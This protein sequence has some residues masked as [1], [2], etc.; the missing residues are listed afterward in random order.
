MHVEETVNPFRDAEGRPRGFLAIQRDVTE[1]RR[2]EQERDDLREQ[3]LA[4]QKLD[5]VGRLAGGIAHDFNNLLAVIL[6]LADMVHASIEDDATRADVQHIRDAGER[7]AELTRQLLTFSRRQVV[8]LTLVDV[9]VLVS[10][11]VTMLR[12]TLG[13]DIEIRTDLAPDAGQVRADKGQLEQVLMNLAVNARDATPHGGTYVCNVAA[14]G[15]DRLGTDHRVRHRLRHGCRYPP[16]CVRAVLHY[17]GSGARHRAG[18][19]HRVRDRAPVGRHHRTA[20]RAGSWNPVHHRVRSS[21]SRP[22]PAPVLRAFA[23]ARNRSCS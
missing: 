6:N 23:E 5:A 18:P 3:Y 19:R 22:R 21:I 1:R 8:T 9:S 4:A 11:L 15:N 10:N 12:R 17:Q 13:E 16:A 7:A 14:A 20:H 2:A